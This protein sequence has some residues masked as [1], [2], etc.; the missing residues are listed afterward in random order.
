MGE[1]ASLS[2]WVNIC[3]YFECGG[4]GFKNSG[5]DNGNKRSIDM[6]SVS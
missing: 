6:S 2:F 1:F 5:R 4:L 3:V